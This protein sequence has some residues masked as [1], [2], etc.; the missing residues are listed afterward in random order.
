MVSPTEQAFSTRWAVQAG[1]AV[2]LPTRYGFP[3]S[4]N[5]VRCGRDARQGFKADAVAEAP[6]RSLAPHRSP[7]NDNKKRTMTTKPTM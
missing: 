3:I 4:V 2:L 5:R 7:K 1:T 6:T